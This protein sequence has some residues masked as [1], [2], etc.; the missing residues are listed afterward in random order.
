MLEER[1]LVP[2]T[3]APFGPEGRMEVLTGVDP[4]RVHVRIQL[5]ECRNLLL[6]PVT[7]IVD[8]DVDSWHLFADTGEKRPVRL[9]ANE[10][11]DPFFLELFAHRIYVD[12]DHLRTGSEVVAPHPERPAKGHTD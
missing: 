12:S 10:Y 9:V 1:I 6:H 5:L 8:E 7:T 11:P 4:V 3:A 2:V